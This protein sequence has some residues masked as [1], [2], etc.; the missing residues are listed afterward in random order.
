M[1]IV[2][3][4]IFKCSDC[5]YQWHSRNYADQKIKPELCPV[6]KSRDWERNKIS[7]ATKLFKCDLCGHKWYSRHFRKEM[8]VSCA[9]CK[10]PHWN[11]GKRELS[12]RGRPKKILLQ[13]GVT[14]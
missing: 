3:G 7:I 2:N 6:C 1:G 10:S 8:P 9:R 4:K 12:K 13:G 5:G 14:A 11:R